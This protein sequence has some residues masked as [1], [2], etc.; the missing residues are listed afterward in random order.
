MEIATPLQVT[1]TSSIITQLRSFRLPIPFT[2]GINVAAFDIIASVIAMII[3]AGWL[4]I[5]RYIGAL[6]AIPIGVVTHLLFKIDTPLTK[7]INGGVKQ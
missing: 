6:L 1:S 7:L 5:P 2:G 3:V 4:G